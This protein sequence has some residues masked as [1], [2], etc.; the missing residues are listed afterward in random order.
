MGIEAAYLTRTP[1]SREMGERAERVMPAGETRAA[2]YHAPYP[3]TLVR[4]DGPKVWD[5]DGNEYYDLICNYTSLVHGHNYGPIVEVA[6]RAVSSGTA[7]P[8]RNPHQVELAELIAERVHSVDSVRF[9]NSGTEAGML[10]LQVARAATGRT[11]LLMAR[12]GYHGSHEAFTAGAAGAKPWDHTLTAKF[13]DANAFE[14][15]LRDRGDEIAAVFLEA[16]PGG[17]ATAPDGFFDRVAGAARQAGAV[18]V[19]DEVITFRLSTGG[20]QKSLSI[21]PDLTMFGKIIGG[22]FPV[23]ALG[24]RRDL[25]DYLDPRKG[26]FNHSGTFNGNPV[27]TAAG[28]VSVRELNAERIAIM[29]GQAEEL[30]AAL[31]RA[32]AAANLNG[33]VRRLGSLLHLSLNEADGAGS[34]IAGPGNSRFHL[35]AMN[36]GVYLSARGLFSL[37]TVLT[38]S[39]LASVKE[40]LGAALGDVG[41][42]LARN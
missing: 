18:F 19:L 30:D 26:I 36:H 32:A 2:G 21:T 7:W 11:K 27:T 10:A 23:G 17:F 14:A 31:T 37:C 15:T 13:G 29:D 33:T 42:E 40:R 35:A 38:D 1:A 20:Y 34:R 16:A 12:G 28:V 39:D 41:A 22:G 9:C 4:G 25:M 5:L 8:A 6:T 3:L 24:G